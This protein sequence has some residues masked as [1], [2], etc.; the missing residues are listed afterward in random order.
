[1]Q[2]LEGGRIGQVFREKDKVY[3]PKG[4]WSDAV[5]QLLLHLHEV[6]FT[7]APYP[8]GFDD[9]GNEIVSY[10]KGDVYNYPLVG[11]I[12]T[13]QA[14]TSAATLLRCFHDA[15]LSF[16]NSSQ[17][18][19]LQWMLPSRNVNEVICHGDFAPYNVALIDKQTVAI[20]DFDTAHPAPRVWDVAYAIYC[21]SPFK[22][23]PFDALG[24]I[25]SQSQR[26]KMFCDAYQLDEP[27]RKR[28]VQVIIERI[29]TLVDYMQSE[30][31]KN[32]TAFVENI[33]DG[34]HLAYLK[35]IRYLQDNEQLITAVLCD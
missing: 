32:N 33:N 23:D 26:A 1:M 17:T 15:T 11:N 12:A 5:H 20:F 24:D 30:A 22:T 9:Q 34:H 2:T 6:G 25:N 18:A 31:K 21:W 27:D 14:L 4:F 8:I 29:R 16:V 35:D 19:D 28:L 3:R 13:E 10:V 7:G